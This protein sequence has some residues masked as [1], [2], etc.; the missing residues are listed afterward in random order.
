VLNNM[1][2]NLNIPF[3][4]EKEAL[5]AY[6]AL[7]VEKEPARSKV[8]REMH[9]DGSVLR[10]KFHA[11]TARNLRVSVNGF[12]EHLALVGETMLKFGPPL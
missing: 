5:I 11:E 1:Q 4:S 8:S 6:D 2:L 10:V 7:R 12:L 9:H 3:P